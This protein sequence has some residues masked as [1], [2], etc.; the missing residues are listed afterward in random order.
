MQI[1]TTFSNTN[2]VSIISM[3]NSSSSFQSKKFIFF[4]LTLIWLPWHA[5]ASEF[6]GNWSAQLIC[7]ENLSNGRPGFKSKLE[8]EIIQGSI[9]K[10][11]TS[12][13]QLGQEQT[14]WKGV[15]QDGVLS[16]TAKS[17][18]DNGDHWLWSL[19]GKAGKHEIS[20]NGDMLSPKKTVLRKCTIILRPIPT[21][22][23]STVAPL[24]NTPVLNPSHPSLTSEPL[25]R[26][27]I[28]APVPAKEPS[29]EAESTRTSP[30]APQSLNIVQPEVTLVAQQP[31]EP[32]IRMRYWFPLLGLITLFALAQLWRHKR[33]PRIDINTKRA[34]PRLMLKSPAPR[35]ANMT[36]RLSHAK[37]K[38]QITTFRIA[39]ESLKKLL[40]TIN[41]NPL[42]RLSFI[43]PLASK[44]VVL[45]AV[46][47]IFKVTGL[48]AY[49]NNLVQFFFIVVAAL[50]VVRHLPLNFLSQSRTYPYLVQHYVLI[51]QTGLFIQ[52]YFAFFNFWSNSVSLYYF[53]INFTQVLA[54]IALTFFVLGHIDRN[55]L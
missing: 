54:Y 15:V 46:A 48:H 55:A 9:D 31:S 40:S 26:E 23:A 43:S 4:L 28:S 24:D 42:S 5:H 53:W 29:P 38:L 44:L 18:R 36:H 51:I 41:T 45:G 32:W 50:V 27:S 34:D 39:R 33:K 6:D 37:G 35:L 19:N 25:A 13:S 17:K 7:G 47:A 22:N 1:K 3:I 12:S 20:L 21:A 14:L 2:H 30:L 8:F 16:L 49:V 10:Q 11:V 52:V